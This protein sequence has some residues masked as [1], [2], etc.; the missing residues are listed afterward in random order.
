M[1]QKD[2]LVMILEFMKEQLEVIMKQKTL[3]ETQCAV[4]VMVSTITGM[5]MNAGLQTEEQ[6]SEK[7]S[8][9]YNEESKKT[10]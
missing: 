6:K 10:E 1:A 9:I 2:T 4:A 3:H 8:V 5:C 7:E